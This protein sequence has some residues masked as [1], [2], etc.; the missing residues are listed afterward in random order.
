MTVAIIKVPFQADLLQQVDR[1]VDKKVCSRT[2]VILEATKMYIARKQNWQDLFSFGDSLAMKNNLSEMD[3]I[4]EIKAYRRERDI[5]KKRGM[6]TIRR[7]I[8]TVKDSGDLHLFE[9]NIV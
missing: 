2:D 9:I 4:N 8:E 7:T 3:V 5:A 6:G 1:F